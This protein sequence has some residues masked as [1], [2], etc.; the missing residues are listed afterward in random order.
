MQIVHERCCGL[1]VH[2]KTVVACVLVTEAGGGARRRV[3]TFGT[4]TADLL[5]LGDWLDRFAVA[6]IAME[7]TGVYWR[8][9][10]NLFEREDRRITLVNP[11]HMRAV[12]RR[13]TDVK[14]SEWLAGDPLG[15][16]C[17][18]AWSS[19]ASSRPSR[20]ATSAS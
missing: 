3:R 5:D 1:D 15:A 11:Q 9:I 16:C 20:S 18:T 7:S 12:P 2:K 17:A 14:D 10:C 6:E 13:K 19:P 8:P 4:M